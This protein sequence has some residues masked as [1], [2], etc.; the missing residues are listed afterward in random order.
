M[1]AVGTHRVSFRGE[2]LTAGPDYCPADLVVADLDVTDLDDAHPGGG[3]GRAAGAPD[4]GAVRAVV[5]VAQ[6]PRSADADA[7]VEAV[8]R[9]RPERLVAVGDGGTL[10]VAKHAWNLLAAG[11]RPPLV[12][13][14][15]GAEPWRAFAP[16]SSLYEPDGQRVSRRY[17]D[18]TGQQVRLDSAALAARQPGVRH[19]HRADTAVHAVEVLTG[20]RAG[21]WGR[22]LA[23]GALA[24]LADDQPIADLVAA[25][26][27][28]EA[29]AAAGLGLA[30]ALAS[31]LGA[32]ARRRHDLPNVLLAPAV[33]E[34]W[35]TRVDWTPVAAAVNCHADAGS[36]ARWLR[37]LRDRADV[38]AT[39][40]AAGFDRALL[41]D[42]VPQAMRSSGMP[43]LP[44]PVDATTLT[45][46]LDRAWVNR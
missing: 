12:L 16:F 40:T 41:A 7:V 17:E 43:W 11:Q 37:E 31:P 30:H 44:E 10:D 28:T 9:H 20:R 18:L 4:P 5:P 46:L 34:F 19:L 21:P 1:N 13:V 39:L 22:A 25:G 3:A 36:V 15:A 35:G 29:F 27:A 33:A 42:V 14:P 6:P 32:L 38:P 24:A 2:I 26:L 45:D 23:A 8:R